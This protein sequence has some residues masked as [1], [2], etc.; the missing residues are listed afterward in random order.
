MD[1][2]PDIQLLKKADQDEWS[3]ALDWL[4]PVA[5][6]ESKDK[7]GKILPNQIEDIA[8]EA[9]HAVSEKVHECKHSSEIKAILRKITR[10]MAV[11][12]LRKHY[13]IKRGGGKVVSLDDDENHEE[14]PDTTIENIDSKYSKLHN[15]DLIQKALQILSEK[16]RNCIN[17]LFY[18]GKSH[19]QISDE[20]NIPM[21]SIGV[22]KKRSLKKMFDLLKKCKKEV[23]KFDE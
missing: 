18:D 16:E 22:T 11:D 6:W 8:I 13:A 5:K 17:A 4:M 10:N 21:G 14:I 1:L 7:L 12:A 19:K 20:F 9:I 2:E 3:K 15:G 23:R